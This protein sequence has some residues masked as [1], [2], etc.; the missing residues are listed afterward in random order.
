MQRS[1]AQTAE[2]EVDGV[3][4]VPPTQPGNPQLPGA[5]VTVV[6]NGSAPNLVEDRG[7]NQSQ[8]P[9]LDT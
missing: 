9:V 1:P 7:A 3:G 6:P 8:P 2:M 5:S 4:T